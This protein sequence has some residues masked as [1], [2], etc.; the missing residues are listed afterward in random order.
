MTRLYPDETNGV[1]MRVLWLYGLFTLISNAAFLIG[2]YLLPEGILRQGPQVTPANTAAA[3]PTFASELLFT[4]L[5]NLGR[6]VMVVVVMNLN[7]LKG[8][9]LGYLL[10]LTMG[11]MSGLVPGSNSFVASDLSDFTVREGMALGLSIGN[12]EML[13]YICVT[14]AT[15]GLGIYE[16]GGQWKD[17]KI[18]PIREVRLARSEV[19]MVLVG[20]GLL[21]IAAV[22]ETMMARGGL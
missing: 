22:R 17:V 16:W 5:F 8:F 19:V 4:L 11:I 10:P 12:V 21:I 7:R 14:A 2:Y 3:A 20:I 9:P 15:V 1:T 18:K 13:G 6:G